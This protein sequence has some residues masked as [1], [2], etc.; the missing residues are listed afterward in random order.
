MGVESPFKLLGI[1][2]IYTLTKFQERKCQFL[3]H[4]MG[5]GWWDLVP[6][7]QESY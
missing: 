1:L 6:S 5:C 2:C 3:A 7:Q 4:V